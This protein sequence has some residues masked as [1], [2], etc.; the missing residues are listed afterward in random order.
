MLEKVTATAP[1]DSIEVF[2]DRDLASAVV[3]LLCTGHGIELG[4]AAVHEGREWIERG[5]L[6]FVLGPTA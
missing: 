5:Y 2:R 6:G 1:D 3:R 4:A